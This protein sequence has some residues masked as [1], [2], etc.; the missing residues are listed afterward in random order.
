M[1]YL[2]CI[3]FG[4]F[5]KNSILRKDIDINKNYKLNG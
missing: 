2:L 3:L 4:M 1:D 5:W